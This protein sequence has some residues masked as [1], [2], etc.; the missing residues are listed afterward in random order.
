[1]TQAP[2]T[3]PFTDVYDLIPTDLAASWIFN[4]RDAWGAKHQYLVDELAKFREERPAVR[5]ELDVGDEEVVVMIVANLVAEKCYPDLLR[6]ARIVID[7]DAAV[8]FF[9]AGQGPLMDE[10]DA[11]HAEVS[12]SRPNNAV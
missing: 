1:M 8:R 2:A 12:V 3:S 9:A 6:A 7:Q 5:A 11:I 4:Q 10:M